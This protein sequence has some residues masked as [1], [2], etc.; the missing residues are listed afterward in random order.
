V[1]GTGGNGGV[2]RTFSFL[3][4]TSGSANT[5]NGGGGGSAASSQPPYAGG[6]ITMGGAGGSGL[7]V[8]QYSA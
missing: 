3:V 1:Y 2:N 8:I 5:G 4:G 6:L 7:V